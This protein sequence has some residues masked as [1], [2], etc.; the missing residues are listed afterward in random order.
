MLSWVEKKEKR[1]GGL[2]KARLCSDPPY[3]EGLHNS[4]TNIEGAVP[5]EV[6]LVH[7]H[8]VLNE[9]VLRPPPHMLSQAA[10][11][12]LVPTITAMAESCE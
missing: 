8:T 1:R 7:A 11:D 6:P 3:K 12:V 4:L 2:G 10:V 9:A 5:W